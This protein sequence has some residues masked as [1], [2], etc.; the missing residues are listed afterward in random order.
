MSFEGGGGGGWGMDN[1]ENCLQDTGSEPEGRDELLV[2][3]L[4]DYSSR[5][6]SKQ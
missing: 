2:L 6:N 4:A 3:V 5:N 1:L